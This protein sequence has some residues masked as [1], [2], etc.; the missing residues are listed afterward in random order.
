MSYGPDVEWAQ[1]FTVIDENQSFASMIRRVTDEYESKLGHDVELWITEWGYRLGKHVSED[2]RIDEDLAASFLPRL[3]ILSGANGARVV[4]WHNLND[5]RDGPYGLI[6]NDGTKRAT[7]TAFRTMSERLGDQRLL[8]QIEGADHPTEGVQAYLFKGPLEHQLVAWAMT[9]GHR[10]EIDTGSSAP[11]KAY[12]KFG[13]SVA[14]TYQR[15]GLPVVE[16][17]RSPVYITGVLGDVRLRE[18]ENSR[19]KGQEAQET[20]E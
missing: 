20:S 16:L 18:V 5:M 19:K 6:R 1:P 11:L 2:E 12:D 17:G 8:E 3:Y 15:D 13:E 7:Y 4:M 9:D 14:I 10:V